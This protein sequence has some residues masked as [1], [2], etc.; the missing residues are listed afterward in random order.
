MRLNLLVASHSSACPDEH[1]P[2]I[3][4]QTLV[5][6]YYR[7]SPPSAMV[8]KV[9]SLEQQLPPETAGT[10]LEKQTLLPLSYVH[11]FRPWEWGASRRSPVDP[12]RNVHCCSILHRVHT[13]ACTHTQKERGERERLSNVCA[14]GSSVSLYHHLKLMINRDHLKH[15]DVR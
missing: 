2:L 6:L 3:K 13:C 9:W 12:E 8:F 7:S 15:P 10:L 14:L 4:T 5:F 1:T 11:P